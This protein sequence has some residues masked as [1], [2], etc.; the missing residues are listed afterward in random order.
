MVNKMNENKE[1]TDLINKL[2]FEK[3]HQSDITSLLGEEGEL[4]EVL[5]ALVNDG[6]ISQEKALEIQKRL[7]REYKNGEVLGEG[8]FTRLTFLASG[9]NIREALKVIDIYTPSDNKCTCCN[10]GFDDDET[11][12]TYC[13]YNLA[14]VEEEN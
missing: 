11:F 7:I 1:K 10:M 12:C 9:E 4:S 6:I 5:L 3:G 13:G 14:Y 2:L 8:I